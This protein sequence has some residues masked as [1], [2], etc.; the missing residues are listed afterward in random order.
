AARIAALAPR[1][2]HANGAAAAEL[3]AP[4]RHAA[5]HASAGAVRLVAHMGVVAE[6][7]EQ[8]RARIYALRLAGVA[9]RVAHLAVRTGVRV[10][11]E[12][13]ARREADACPVEAHTLL[14]RRAVVRDVVADALGAD[15]APLGVPARRP[16]RALGLDVEPRLRCGVGRGRARAKA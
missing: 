12:D 6:L 4:L 3:L 14:G 2:T 15:S 9:D 13:R 7:V 8:A 10:S 1:G 16:F 11:L 5:D